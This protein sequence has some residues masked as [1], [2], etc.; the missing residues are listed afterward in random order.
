MQVDNLTL[1]SE[2]APEVVIGNSSSEILAVMN[3]TML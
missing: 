3:N 2:M 1:P